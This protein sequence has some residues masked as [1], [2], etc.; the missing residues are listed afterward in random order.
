[1]EFILNLKLQ[2]NLVL[3]FLASNE[4]TLAIKKN[5]LYYE[6]ITVKI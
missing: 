5:M 1:M 3:Y 4:T 6:F 2:L